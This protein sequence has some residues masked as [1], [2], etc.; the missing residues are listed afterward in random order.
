MAGS[1]YDVNI[2][3]DV[4]K[5]NQQISN[6]ERRISKLNALAQ[7]KRGDSKILLK[8]E[9]DKAALILK[10]ERAQKR[11]NKELAKTN[12]L[13]K[14]ELN[15]T[16]RATKTGGGTRRTTVSGRPMGP[17]SPLNITN[18]GTLLPGKAGGLVPRGPAFT[19]GDI[20]GALISGAFPLLFGQGPLGAAA[21]FGGGLIGSKIGGQ[22]GGFAGG[23]VAT[24]LLTQAQQVFDATSKLGQAFSSLTPDVEGLTTA[25]GAAGT[26]RERQIQLIKKTE[27]TQAALAAVTEQMNKAIGTDSVAKLKEFGELSRLIGN[28]FKLMATKMYVA[29]LPLL[30]L[31]ST[32]FAG[33][34]QREET[35]RLAEVGGSATDP[36][37]LALQQE[38]ANVGPGKGRSGVKRANERKAEL[39]AQIDARIEELSL[40]GKTLE[41]QTTINM[42]EDSRLKKVRQQNALL[43]AKI[44]G[45]YE[46]VLLA[47]E[48]DAKIKE[49]IEDGATLEEL[50]VNKIENLLKQNNLLEKQAEQAEKV[51]QQFKSLGQ[52]L[53]T[54]VADGLQGLIRGT[55]TLNDMLSNVMNKLIDA[56]F[57]MAL[58]GNPGGTL[59]GGG[60]FGSLFSGLGSIFGGK[61][62]PTFGTGIPSGANLLPGSFGISSIQRAA[63]GPVK[64]G[65]GYLVGE[66]G[67]EMFTPG[68]S[69]MITPNHALG[70]TT[71]VVVN[72]DAS[73]SSVEGDEE[74]GRELGRL[75]SAAVQSELIQQKRPGGILA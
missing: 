58:F 26:E 46:E 3:L 49:M 59:G 48:L 63:G 9:R 17:S 35:K 8:N 62:D 29:L 33:P 61:S 16:K 66:R 75:I 43:Q 56:A 34:A 7:G 65:S 51:R 72:V 50:D 1:N 57:N 55:S 19:K 40:V 32:P 24:A 30:N 31:L 4:R 68:V 25:L 54:D 71:N 10:Q 38:L 5:I 15:L 52:S 70:G 14:E 28:Q 39:Q 21:G 20:S 11:V 74:Q 13:K 6:L 27:G 69:G 22:T 60:L 2:K 64:G 18:Q 73:G 44:D 37:L 42:I 47:Q 53:A 36:A 41:R 12:R 45:N 23:L 67:P